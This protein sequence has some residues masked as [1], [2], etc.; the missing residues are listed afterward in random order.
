MPIFLGGVDNFMKL[1]LS[2][3]C[4]PYDRI[5]PL[6]CG[7]VVPSDKTLSQMLDNGELD[8]LFAVRPPSCF[9]SGSANVTRLFQD[10]RKVEEQYYQKTG[11]FPIMHTVIIRHDIYKRDPWVRSRIKVW[12]W[13][14]AAY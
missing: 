13:F 12:V 6:S 11:I 1:S 9:E 7:K 8:P 3:A 5:L 2:F 4:P 14:W 10:Y